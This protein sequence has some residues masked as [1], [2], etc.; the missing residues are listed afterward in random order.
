[1]AASVWSG[2]LTF[3]MISIPVK[4]FSAARS[5]GISF[6]MLHRDDLSRLKQ[7]YVCL[8]DNQVV[9]RSEIVKGYEYRKDEYVVIL[10]EEI[11]Q[12]EPKTSKVMELLEFVEAKSV[13][14]IYLESS[15]YIGPDEAGRLPY[16]LLRGAMKHGSYYGIAKLTMHNREYTVIIRPYNDILALHTMYYQDEVRE[17]EFKV[18]NDVPEAQVGKA[19]ELIE[20][21]VDN[22]EPAKYSDNFQESLKELIKSKIEGTPLAKPVKEE[23]KSPVPDIMEAMRQSLAQ[24]AEKKAAKKP[25]NGGKK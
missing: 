21:M 20:A 17:P 4:L 24:M 25:K 7:Q 12:V 23:K 13:D 5:Q 8:V 22:F 6:N 3:G 9:E 11:K 14:P 10:P 18:L 19:L 15:Y 1:M 16:A 2:Y